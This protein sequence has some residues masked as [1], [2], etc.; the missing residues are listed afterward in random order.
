LT[1]VTLGTQDFPFN[2]L[3]ELVDRLV[4]E[5]AVNK[6]MVDSVTGAC[7]EFKGEH[8]GESGYVHCKCEKCGKLVH[9]ERK[10]IEAAMQSL[11]GSGVDGGFELDCARTL[12]YGICRDCRGR[13]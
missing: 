4:E 13:R 11:S 8:G 5:G 9:L 1:F 2:R 10:R 3:L 7:Y 6:Y 12:F